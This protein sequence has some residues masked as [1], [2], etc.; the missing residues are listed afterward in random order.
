[1]KSTLSLK[2]ILFSVIVI[3]C[4]QVVI[5]QTWTFRNGFGQSGATNSLPDVGRAI[6][7]D[8][9][10]NVYITGKISD[11][12]TGNTVSFGGTA[13]VSDGDDDGFVAKFNS[14]GVHQWSIRFG[15]IGF[16]DIGNGIATDGTSVYVVG[17]ANGAMTVGTSATSYPGVGT[18]TDGVIMKLNAA[19]GAVTWVTRFGGGNSDI[20]QSVAVD[21]SV[22]LSLYGG[23]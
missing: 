22:P 11:D 3:L 13:L 15:G 2:L 20:A 14:A 21:P 12:L 23:V 6:C 4:T 16:V 19:T 7:T 9:S 1:M 8:A 18:G 5:A 10:G 17:A